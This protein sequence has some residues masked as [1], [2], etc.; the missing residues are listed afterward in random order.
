MKTMPEKT[1]KIRSIPITLVLLGMAFWFACEIIARPSHTYI[2]FFPMI[3]DYLVLGGAIF[4]FWLSG[5]W[6]MA[7]LSERDE[8]LNWLGLALVCVALV[9]I[10]IAIY[11][12]N[13]GF[14]HGIRINVRHMVGRVLVPS[15]FWPL[16]FWAVGLAVVLWDVLS[17][18][19]ATVN[20]DQPRQNRPQGK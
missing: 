13:E 9:F 5:L 16:V 6:T 4:L 17:G 11:R 2:L 18:R 8:R 12:D 19:R 15:T 10:V 7:K 3:S 14:I 1:A 20:R